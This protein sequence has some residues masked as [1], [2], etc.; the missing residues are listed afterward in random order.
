VSMLFSFLKVLLDTYASDCFELGG[1]KM[2]CAAVTVHHRSSSSLLSCGIKIITE[3][4]Y[5]INTKL[6]SKS[7][8]TKK[9]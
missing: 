9:N 3:V 7:D 5:E 1:L 2:E 6:S 8:R 4:L